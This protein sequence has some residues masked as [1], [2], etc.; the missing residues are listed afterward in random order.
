[1]KVKKMS[2]RR[3]G[4]RKYKIKQKKDERNL[5]DEKHKKNSKEIK[6]FE[7]RKSQR[8]FLLKTETRL[9]TKKRKR[10]ETRIL[11]KRTK[12]CFCQT[13]RIKGKHFQKRV[14]NH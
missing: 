5:M 9:I 3:K 1:M 7:I 11:P 10:I 13:V 2:S 6:F 12:Q 8:K 4:S 14:V